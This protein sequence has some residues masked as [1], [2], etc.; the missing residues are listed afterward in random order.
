MFSAVSHLWPWY[1]VW[2]IAFAALLPGWWLSRFIAG[3][4]ILVPFMLPIWWIDTFES[5][6][7]LLTTGLYAGA[8]LWVFLTRERRRHAKVSCAGKIGL[9]RAATAESPRH[10]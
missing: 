9:N 4:A 7:D 2:G 10:Q 1:L 8:G 6:R 5:H 3:I